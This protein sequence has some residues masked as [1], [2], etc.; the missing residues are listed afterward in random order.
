MDRSVLVDRIRRYVH[1][2]N[3]NLDRTEESPGAFDRV[4]DQ[5]RIRASGPSGVCFATPKFESQVIAKRKYTQR[6]LTIDDLG[7]DN[8]L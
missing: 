7:F 4:S 6:A 8:R 5:P 1:V 3:E 2:A